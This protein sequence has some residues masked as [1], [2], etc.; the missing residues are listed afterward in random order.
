ML[1]NQ[2]YG[3]YN[4]KDSSTTGRKSFAAFSQVWADR[5]LEEADK[6]LGGNEHLDLRLKTAQ[7]LRDYYDKLMARINEAQAMDTNDV[8]ES[9]ALRRDQLAAHVPAA[10]AP[11]AAAVP[12]APLRPSAPVV[13]QVVLPN[14]MPGMPDP[15]A[16]AAH[17]LQRRL[18][19]DPLHAAAP[20]TFPQRTNPEPRSED[21]Q[22]ST[23]ALCRGC[24]ASKK[25]HGKIPGLT[26]FAVHE[27]C[28]RPCK[29][30][31]T[32]VAHG[33][34]AF[35]L[36]CNKAR[37]EAAPAATAATATAATAAGAD[38]DATTADATAAAAA[39]A[40]AAPAAAAATAATAAA[41]AAAAN[42][43]AT[44]FPLNHLYPQAFP[45]L[46]NAAAPQS[47][48]ATAPHSY[49][50]GGPV[51]RT[52]YARPITAATAAGVPRVTGWLLP[53]AY[54]SIPTQAAFVLATRIY[55]RMNMQRPPELL[56]LPLL[57][58]PSAPL[59][60]PVAKPLLIIDRLLIIEAAAATVAEPAVAV[61]EAA[62]AAAVPA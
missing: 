46:G 5:V 3:S 33:R 21:V 19:S 38:V 4:R 27:K 36:L 60:L 22:P 34:D 7:H 12:A 35:G 28:N 14:Q 6:K 48:T 37:L 49:G 9:Q 42:V 15:R 52:A 11:G 59:L 50:A 47:A 57:P 51:R 39:T 8:A 41:A 25:G 13:A 56:S 40:T 17:Q 20:Y 26:A 58:C 32:L 43:A 53:G 44:F 16:S 24:G 2:L 45:Y 61:A 29:C 62:A 55:H 1:F 30:G 54:D 31:R 10:A 18:P 23:E